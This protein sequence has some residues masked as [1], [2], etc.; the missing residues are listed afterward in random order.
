MQNYLLQIDS[1]EIQQSLN[2]TVS[3]V[4]DQITPELP[5]TTFVTDLAF[6]M[7]IGAIVTLAFFKIKQP[8]PFGLGYFLMVVLHQIL[9]G[10]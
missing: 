8:L 5:H 10:V 3:N 6:I 7:I 2:E 4:I 1:G 9:L